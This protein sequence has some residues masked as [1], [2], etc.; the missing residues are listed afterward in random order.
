MTCKNGHKKSLQAYF[1][2]QL[3]GKELVKYEKHLHS[4]KVCQE[5]LHEIDM[6]SDF[7]KISQEKVPNK[8]NFDLIWDSV[9]HMLVRDEMSFGEH[10]HSAVSQVFD[11]IRM[12]LR[13][14]IA[15]AFIIVLFLLPL[16]EK[17]EEVCN[18]QAIK[19]VMLKSI[20]SSRNI[21]LFTTKNKGWQVVWVGGESKK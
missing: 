7:L 1:D 8:K 3:E 14:A 2:G 21:M 10:T 11:A 6:V 17:E 9:E 20:T 15:I 5:K 18:D 16:G 12:M 19:E 4:C 13:P